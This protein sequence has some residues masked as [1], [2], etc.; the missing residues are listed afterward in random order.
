[1][2]KVYVISGLGTDERVFQY[3]DFGAHQPVFIP[4]LLPDKGETIEQYASR[5]CKYIITPNPILIGLS[6]GGMVAVEIAKQIDT[7][8]VV[9]L[10]SAKNYKEIPLYLRGLGKIRLQNIIPPAWLLYP[11]K[12]VFWWL[13]IREKE[14]QNLIASVFRDTD[15]TLY[16]WSANAIL[17][18]RNRQTPSNILHIHGR[19]DNVLPLRFIKADRV[20]NGGHFCLITHAKEVSVYLQAALADL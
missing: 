2:A 1:M 10:S 17:T 8:K 12:L 11:N 20:V 14:H 3:I 9:L 18:W 19:G 13:K 5:L 16:R 4:W 15:H 7:Q 6:F